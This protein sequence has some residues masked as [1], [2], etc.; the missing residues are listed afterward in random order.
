MN[1][2]YDNKIN[3]ALL[4]SDSILHGQD[5]NNLKSVFFSLPCDFDIPEPVI[6]CTWEQEPVEMDSFIISGRFTSADIDLFRDDDLIHSFSVGNKEKINIFHCPLIACDKMAITLHEDQG[7]VSVNYIYVGTRY[8]APRFD[9]QPTF[10]DQFTAKSSRSDFGFLYGLEGVVLRSV[11]LNY[12]RMTEADFARLEQYYQSVQTV[13][14]HIVDFYPEA[15]KSFP[16]LHC[17]LAKNI[18][19]EKRIENGFYYGLPLEYNEAK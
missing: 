19:R 6:E 13:V 14:P 10:K 1:I 11:S 5:I 4:Y 2:Y 16:P 9:A 17:T 8:E 15:H 3:S 12:T 18:D 7:E